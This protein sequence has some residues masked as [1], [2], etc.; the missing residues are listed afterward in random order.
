M[1]IFNVVLGI[2]F[3][4]SN[5]SIWNFVNQLPY[6]SPNWGPINVSFVPR[7]YVVDHFIYAQ[8]VVNLF[9]YP[10]WLFWIAIIGNMLFAFLI[11][12]KK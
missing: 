8:I 12:R 10:F 5:Y 3:V 9:N 11:Q 7:D 2:L 6:T 4:L 1:I